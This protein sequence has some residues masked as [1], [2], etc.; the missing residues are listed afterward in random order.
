MVL[1][2]PLPAN[3]AERQKMDDAINLKS[4]VDR[5]SQEI[6]SRIRL[7][8]EEPGPALGRTTA[9]TIRMIKSD[10]EEVRFKEK[11]GE[12]RETESLDLSGSRR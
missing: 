3:P 2:A 8:G 7:P 4:K 9:R 5:A 12:A 1:K 11:A 10:L 6:I